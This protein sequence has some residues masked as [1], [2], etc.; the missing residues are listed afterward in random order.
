MLQSRQF[1]E[2]ANE[3]MK[4]EAVTIK[5]FRSVS[6][7][8]LVD[9]SGF[10]VL[11]GKNNSGKSNIL[12]SINAFF[13]AVREG[14]L[15]CLTPTIDKE[16]D[17][18]DNN[19]AD[20]AE[21]TLTFTMSSDERE[22]LV[23]GIRSD[24]PQL[25]NAVNSLDPA[26]RL[27]VR[28]RFYLKPSIYACVSRISLV[29]RIQANGLPSESESIIL[30]VSQEA[31][32]KLHE[33]YRQYQDAEARTR[34]LREFLQSIDRDDWSQM[35]MYLSEDASTHRRPS[36]LGRRFPADQA[37]SQTIETM[38]RES[39]THDEFQNALRAM[40]SSSARYAEIFDRH[41]LDQES[42]E[43]FSG[44]GTVVPE[45][46]VS[47][48][49][50]LSE[51]KVL[52]V[53]DERRPIG[54]GEAQRLLNLKTRRGGQEP[55]NR[56]QGVVST[57]LGVQI[58]AFSGEQT[59]RQ[60]SPVAELDVDNFV[61]EV[62]GSGIKEALRLLLDIEFE[63]PNLLIVEEPEIH[64]HPGLETALMRHL[65]EV[66]KTRQVFITTHSTNFLDTA[67]VQNIYLIS[68]DTSTTAQLL[69]RREVEELVPGELGIRLSSLFIYDRLV[70]VES[71]SDEDVIRTWANTF[72][73]ISTSPMLDSFTWV[74]LEIF[75]TL[76][77]GRRYRSFLSVESS[78][79]S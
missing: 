23:A 28:V 34:V 79:G 52:N 33:K 62:N 1:L 24:F 9:C 35:K 75:L 30:D 68:K 46:V 12:S 22:A 61:V 44:R 45:H 40:I 59:N 76:R 73:I 48:L 26:S 70:F 36:T 15:V 42:V 53:T 18:F 38:V 41:G 47:I 25:T 27:R 54:R 71:Q 51:V 72:G 8:D 20:P 69:D 58:D 60:G 49:R 29:S 21:V 3:E 2:S 16:V 4:V 31:A 65:E 19:A 64:L 50:G 6:N 17:F 63:E 39:D 32:L 7:C 11:I 66:S 43:T 78:C 55:L 67:A 14:A 57:L 10:N 13:L 5:N 74:D 56:I 37:T 77:G